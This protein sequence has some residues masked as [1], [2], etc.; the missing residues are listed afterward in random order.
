MVA[1]RQRFYMIFPF[2]A[3]DAAA[4]ADDERIV[5]TLP[6]RYLRRYLLVIRT[7]D[8]F[9]MYIIQPSQL[10]RDESRPLIAHV[11]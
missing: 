9:G 10:N 6:S 11:T 1:G 8:P 4:S 2:G 3:I 7:C 5:Q